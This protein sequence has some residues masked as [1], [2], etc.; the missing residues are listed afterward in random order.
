M[1]EKLYKQ[2]QGDGYKVENKSWERENEE[3]EEERRAKRPDQ[4]TVFIV[5][6]GRIW[7]YVNHMGQLNGGL[8]F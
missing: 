3:V 1:N 4:S 7:A 5:E 8:T 6:K 2:R